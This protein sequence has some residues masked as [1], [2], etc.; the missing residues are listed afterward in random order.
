M[1]IHI[2]NYSC[3]IGPEGPKGVLGVTGLPGNPGVQGK[4][5]G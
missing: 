1:A 2:I 4:I 3:V 5:L